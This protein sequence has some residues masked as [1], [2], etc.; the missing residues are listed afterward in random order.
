MEP[1]FSY[2]A[3]WKELKTQ[4]THVIEAVANCGVK[5]QRALVTPKEAKL[6]MKDY[7]DFYVKDTAGGVLIHPKADLFFEGEFWTT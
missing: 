6:F 3:N 4:T 7:A 1:P 2:L 5:L